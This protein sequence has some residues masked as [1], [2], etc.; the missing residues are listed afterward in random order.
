MLPLM[1]QEVVRAGAGT[2]AAM[3]ARLKATG[4]AGPGISTL[5]SMSN[6]LTVGETSVAKALYALGTGALSASQFTAQFSGA[7]LDAALS[8]SAVRPSAMGASG[9]PV[10]SSVCI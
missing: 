6:V 2:L 7:A 10:S 8:Q 5:T 9:Y 4:D 3:N 1:Q